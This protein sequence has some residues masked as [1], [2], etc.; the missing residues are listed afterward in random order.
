MNGY[1]EILVVVMLTA[2]AGAYLVRKAVLRFRPGA[3]ACGRCGCGCDKST[4]A[5]SSV[6]TGVT[7][8]AATLTIGG[9]NAG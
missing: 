5:A 9:R 4:P 2:V 7:T 8:K 3:K 6:E 1:T